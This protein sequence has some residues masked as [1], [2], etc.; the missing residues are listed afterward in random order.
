MTG[1]PLFHNHMSL[2]LANQFFDFGTPPMARLDRLIRFGIF[3]EVAKSDLPGLIFTLVWAVD[4]PRDEAYVDEISD[5]FIK[6]G[7]TVQLVE[8]FA[9]QEARLERNRHPDRL[10]AKPSKRDLEYSEKVLLYQDKN[11]RLSTQ[12]GD[13]PDKDILRIDNTELSPEM[14]ADRICQVLGIDKIASMSK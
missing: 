1:I 11:Y 9:T 13:L 14:V 8:L 12:A 10:A 4:Q 5:L 7:G 6:E 3:N 2:E